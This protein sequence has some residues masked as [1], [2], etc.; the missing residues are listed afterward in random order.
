MKALNKDPKKRY[1]SGKEFVQDLDLFLQGKKSKAYQEV[2]KGHLQKIFSRVL[3]FLLVCVFFGGVWFW[4]KAF[5]AKKSEKR[6]VL[7]QDHKEQK[8]SAKEISLYSRKYTIYLT[9]LPS[10]ISGRSFSNAIGYGSKA[11]QIGIKLKKYKK[12]HLEEAYFLRGLANQVSLRNREALLDYSKAISE[13]PHFGWPYFF[14]SMIYY[15]LGEKEKSRKDFQRSLKHGL[16]FSASQWESVLQQWNRRLKVEAFYWDPKTKN[17]YAWGKGPGF[18][19]ESF[20]RKTPHIFWKIAYRPIGEVEWTY[21]FGEKAY[22]RIQ[23]YLGIQP[24]LPRFTIQIER[25]KKNILGYTE[26]H[27]GEIR[28]FAGFWVPFFGTM[29]LLVQTL[30]S[31]FLYSSIGP[32]WPYDFWET[33]YGPFHTL[34][35]SQIMEDL[36]F[37]EIAQ[38][39]RDAQ[40]VNPLFRLY[41][42]WTHQKGWTF[43]KAFFQSLK[44]DEISFYDMANRFPWSRRCHYIIAYLSMAYGANLAEPFQKAGL[45]QKP[46]FWDL[47]WPD[48]E[49][50]PYSISKKEI[51][52]ILFLRK[53]LISPKFQRS[54]LSQK[55]WDAFRQGDI[56]LTEKIVK[57]IR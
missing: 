20:T 4:G 7:P 53:I 31:Q 1:Q 49:F 45:G 47:K 10:F 44:E 46:Y 14:R 56:D 11:I 6:V 12:I 28:L 24:S 16:S 52:R 36:N 26:T 37:P 27:F 40:K 32:H 42:K 41:E 25:R 33:Q 57:K 38:R 19:H 29:E 35:A 43:W 13:N 3:A 55:A 39:I 30:T 2:Q 8:L 23:E 34:L 51:N 15:F 48:K 22:S 50:Q 54:K 21:D 5:V 9:S 18:P 17:F